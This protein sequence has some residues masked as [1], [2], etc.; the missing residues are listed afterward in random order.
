VFLTHVHTQEPN[1]MKDIHIEQ[2]NRVQALTDEQKERFLRIYFHETDHSNVDE[3]VL[4]GEP[5]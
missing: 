4:T 3:A 2:I 5:E 1:K